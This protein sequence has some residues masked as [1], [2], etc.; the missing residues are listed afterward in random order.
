M[1]RL[2][3]LL[4]SIALVV[5]SRAETPDG[6]LRVQLSRADPTSS[7]SGVLDL[8]GGAL[9]PTEIEAQPATGFGVVYEVRFADRWGLESGIFI[10][11]FDFDLTAIG[12]TTDFGSALA[13]PLTLGVDFHPY[14]SQ[15]LDV[16][17]G[18]LI[19]YTVWGNLDTSAGVS[20]VDSDFGVG[21]VVG[22]DL[23]LGA[24]DWTLCLAA[25]YI[26][27]DL[28]DSSLA[29]GVD[30]LFAEVGLGYRF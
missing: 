5:P 19:A 8:G 17:V 2:C 6:T 15:R 29:I 21:V 16:Y 30:P 24:S 3:W 12:A 4:L 27:T 22:L 9:I 11:D 20:E 25:R 28:A 7:W 18:P 10:A 26:G 14:T 13:I 1:K 23:T